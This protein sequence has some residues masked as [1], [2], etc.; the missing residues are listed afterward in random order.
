MRGFEQVIVFER[1]HIR[2][3]RGALPGKKVYLLSELAED[4]KIDIKDPEFMGVSESEKI[5]E[6]IEHSLKRIYE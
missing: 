1:S 2:R 5:F 4:K 6:K 3:V